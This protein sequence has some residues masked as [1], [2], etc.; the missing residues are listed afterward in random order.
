MAADGRNRGN[1]R[2]GAISQAPA[3]RAWVHRGAPVQRRGYVSPRGYYYRHYSP[4]IVVVSPYGPFYYYQPQVIEVTTPYFCALHN[5][6]FVTRA[7]MLDHLAGTHKFPL[8]HAA[9]V[10][11]D[12][13]EICIYP[14]Q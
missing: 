8:E 7:G 2:S 11:P 4:P 3:A 6:G 9:R 12:G 5:A 14:V 1:A 10:C 13:V